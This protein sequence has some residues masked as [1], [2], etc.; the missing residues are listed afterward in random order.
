M[1]MN[2]LWQDTPERIEGGKNNEWFTPA[3]Y[4]EAARRVMG[5]IDLDPASC[6]LANKVVKA[7]KYHT[8]EDNGLE[9][10]WYGRVWLNPPYGRIHPDLTG[11]IQS[12]QKAFAEKLLREYSTGNIEQ[13]ILLSL[14]NPN[15]VWFQPFFDYTLCF[16][17]GHIDFYRPDGSTGTFG[18]PLAFVYLGS[19]EKQFINVFSQFGRVVRAIDTPQAKPITPELWQLDTVAS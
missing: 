6:E 1:N 14:G 13:A 19:R 9:R 18:F 16:Y 4:V 7:A 5:E 8:K 15:S 3:R 10:P 17:R 11:S 12:F 2:T